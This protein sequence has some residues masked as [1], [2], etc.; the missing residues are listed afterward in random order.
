[1][2][3][4]EKIEPGCKTCHDTHDAP[5]IK[6]ITM[7]QERCAQKTNPKDL[8]CTDCHGTHRRP[9]RTV[10]WDKTTGRLLSKEEPS[11]A[12]PATNKAQS[13]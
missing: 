3:A 12:K 5:A 2:F 8:L 11:E 7:W 6:V 10:R 9:F 1:M 4:P 13:K